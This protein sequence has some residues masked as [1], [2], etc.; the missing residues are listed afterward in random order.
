MDDIECTLDIIGIDAAL[1]IIFNKSKFIEKDH[2][3]RNSN[4]R[5]RKS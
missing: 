3:F 4:C 2:D 5:N 1:G